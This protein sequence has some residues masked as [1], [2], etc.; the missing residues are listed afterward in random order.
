MIHPLC[1]FPSCHCNG[2][3]YLEVTTTFLLCHSAFTI[4]PTSVDMLGT[5]FVNSFTFY[6]L[7][8]YSM[9]GITYYCILLYKCNNT[10]Y[11]IICL[12]CSM[13]LT[14]FFLTTAVCQRQ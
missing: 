7:L 14:F 3:H 6:P 5:N 2:L 13:L 4:E 8:S 11:I 9:K 12:S 1:F 10:N